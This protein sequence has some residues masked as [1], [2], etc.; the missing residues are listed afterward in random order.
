MSLR[1]IK[2]GQWIIVEGDI[3]A[4]FFY[5]LIKGKVGIFKDGEKITSLEVKKGGKPRMLGFLAALSLNRTHVAS[6][7]TETEIELKSMEVSHLRGILQYDVP[8]SLK[9][10]I[11]SMIETIDMCNQLKSLQK[12]L[13]HIPEVKLNPPKRINQEVAG[14]LSELSGLYKQVLKERKH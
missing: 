7:K 5:K 1:K 3:Q 12:K 9:N 11:N 6:V 8:K 4:Q 14:V 10:N 2:S 13:S